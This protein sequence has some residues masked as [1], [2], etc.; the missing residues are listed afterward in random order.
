MPGP[1]G[2][3]NGCA[4]TAIRAAATSHGREWIERI[5]QKFETR[6]YIMRVLENA[7]VYE[8]M[9]PD[10]AGSGGP[11]KLSQFLGQAAPFNP[12]L[13]APVLVD[14]GPADGPAADGP[15][16]ADPAPADPLAQ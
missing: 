6:N 1:G 5:P 16:L 11:R 13:P 4:R 3:T 9:H 10:K 7:V 2:S 15:P 8:T 12:A 14:A